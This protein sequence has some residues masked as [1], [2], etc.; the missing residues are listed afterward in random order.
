[1]AYELPPHCPHD[2][3]RDEVC[4]QCDA[5]KRRPAGTPLLTVT[6]PLTMFS[7][8]DQAQ[9]DAISKAIRGAT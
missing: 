6:H 9:R 5:D 3:C 2:R 1:M 8:L 4:E 7:A